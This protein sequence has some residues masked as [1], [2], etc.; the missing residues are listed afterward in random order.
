M[1]RLAYLLTVLLCLCIGCSPSPLSKTG[2][3]IVTDQAVYESLFQHLFRSSYEPLYI[4]DTTESQWFKNNPITRVNESELVKL[5]GV[6]PKLLKRLYEVNEQKHPLNWNPYMINAMF[7]NKYYANIDHNSVEN[8]CYVD[9]RD[10]SVEKFTLKLHLRAYYT[11]SKVAFSK[12]KTIA[13]LKYAYHCSPRSGS[14][15]WLV[16]LRLEENAWHVLDY[17]NNWQYQDVSF[18]IGQSGRALNTVIPY[19]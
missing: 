4:A 2:K 5:Q 17:L 12:D 8:T 1:N 18:D 13:L 9:K 7:L 14:G 11:V 16:I 15:D 19:S 3:Q 6:Y 10:A